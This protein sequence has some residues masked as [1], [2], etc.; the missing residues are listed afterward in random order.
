MTAAAGTPDAPGPVLLYDGICGFCNATVRFIVA[1]DHRGTMQFAPLEGAF[2]REVIARHPE[3]RGV[4][5]LVLVRR[6]GPG[7]DRVSTRSEAAIA[8]AAHLGG[9]LAVAARL[10]RMLPRGL[11][12]LAYDV[13]ARHRYRVFGRFDACP[14][15]SPDLRARFLP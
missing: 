8:V 12:D 1:R 15:P 13:F 2:A 7:D 9:G 6:G 14:L 10:A 5:S 4:D 11:R 3:L